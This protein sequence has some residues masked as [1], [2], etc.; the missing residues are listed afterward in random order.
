MA[1]APR[2]RSAGSSGIV[3]TSRLLGQAFGAA[4]AT[5]W[6]EVRTKADRLT[7]LDALAAQMLH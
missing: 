3:A 2:E 4:L 6:P 5:Q 7:H 1:S